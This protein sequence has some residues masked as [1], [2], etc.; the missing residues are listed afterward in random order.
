MTGFKEKPA[1]E[2]T[3]SRIACPCFYYFK[4]DVFV[5]ISDF[6]REKRDVALAERDAT[7]LLL[8]YLYDKVQ[9]YTC[10]IAG[11]FDVGNLKQYIEADDFF[12]NFKR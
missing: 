1:P 2:E 10:P 8:R 4:S 6:L 11:R 5:L 12:N 9:I 3:T 7:G